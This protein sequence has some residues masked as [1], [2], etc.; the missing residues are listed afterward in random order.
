MRTMPGKRLFRTFSVYR[1]I[2]LTAFRGLML[3]GAL[4]AIWHYG[5]NPVVTVVLFVLG[6]SL[7][8]IAADDAVVIYDD[9]IK[10]TGGPFWK[11]MRGRNQHRY[12]NIL[13]IRIEGDHELKDDIKGNLIALGPSH[14]TEG[15]NKIMIT[16][17]N[18]MV[19]EY[20]AEIYRQ[21]IIEALT[22]IP[23]PFNTLIGTT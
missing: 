3:A 8:L 16:M 23:A 5:D 21:H 19:H 11:T 9:R 7:F 18:G 13:V 15:F 6:I 4:F 22:M 20:K 12:E 10:I 14:K 2:K 17:K 1:A